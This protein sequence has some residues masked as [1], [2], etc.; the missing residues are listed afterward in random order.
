MQVLPLPLHLLL[1]PMK[2][3]CHR[4]RRQR[5]RARPR[6]AAP[7]SAKRK[8]FFLGGALLVGIYLYAEDEVAE[9]ECIGIFFKRSFS[10]RNFGQTNKQSAGLPRRNKNSNDKLNS[11]ISSPEEGLRHPETAASH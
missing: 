5:T 3:F 11:S 7:S 1:I 2:P 6:Q 8:P 10:F 4:W 9:G